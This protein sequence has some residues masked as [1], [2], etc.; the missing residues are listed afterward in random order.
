VFYNSLAGGAE[1]AV[2]EATSHE[3]GHN[4]GLSHDGTAALLSS[5][6]YY[7]G[8]G[9]GA[10][11]WAPIMGVGYSRELTQWSQGE[12]PD[13]SNDEDDLALIPSHGAPL[14][15]DDHGSSRASASTLAMQANGGTMTVLQSGVIERRTDLDVFA[16]ETAGGT[17]QLQVTPSPLARSSNLY[18]SA[19]LLDAAGNVVASSNEAS[20]L[21]ATLSAEI[22]AGT[23][24]V[25]VDGVG[26]NSPAPGYP[27]YG[28]LGQYQI[29][30]SVPAAA[31]ALPQ[32][33]LDLETLVV[34]ENGSV[35]VGLNLS[36]PSS[37]TVS[38]AISFS[39]SATPGVDY[40][41][42]ASST[43]SFAPGTT[44][45]SFT[46]RSLDD[47]LNEVH[48]TI[49]YT[50]GTPSGALAGAISTGT[51]RIRDDDAAPEVRLSRSAQTFSEAGGVGFVDV[52]LSAA[53]GRT[54]SVELSIGGSAVNGEDYVRVPT[55]V[56]FA[57]GVTSRRIRIVPVDDTTSE[58]GETVIIGI[59][60][61]RIATIGSPSQYTGTIT[62]ND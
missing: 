2:A 45:A 38:V 8:H 43:V 41:P 17:V 48:E 54:L 20:G 24:Y 51:T 4:L 3:V 7:E 47:A 39:G 27:D 55:R 31:A 35:Q 56:N 34:R 15:S 36:A 19:S 9:S 16:F 57:E 61:S 12:Y 49:V 28:S 60:S 32:V 29:S 37:Q 62:D 25:Q 59:A 6:D 5:Q 46:L 44:S 52:Q 13:A 10:T 11:G 26:D 1:K 33:S 42:P 50:L 22:S 58:A 14:R 23:Y 40:E 21:G 18:V 53:A 30:G